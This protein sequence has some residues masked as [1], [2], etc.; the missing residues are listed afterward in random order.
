MSTDGYE[1]IY[2]GTS[3]SLDA[4]LCGEATFGSAGDFGYVVTT[5]EGAT[6]T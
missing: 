1:Y 2:F 5:V 3:S 4:F 6:L